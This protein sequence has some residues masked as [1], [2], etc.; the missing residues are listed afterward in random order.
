MN[1]AAQADARADASQQ[2]LFSAQ[3]GNMKEKMPA[4]RNIDTSTHTGK[5]VP[6]G[7]EALDAGRKL[8][9]TNPRHR[10]V[11]QRVLVACIN[12]LVTLDEIE[13]RIE[14]DPDATDKHMAPFFYAQWLVDA[15][16]LICYDLDVQG[17]LI[18]RE[19]YPDL[20]DDEY[21]DLLEG[22][23]YSATPEGITVATE[24]D[25][26]ARI[27]VFAERNTAYTACYRD[28]LEYLT[29]PHHLG[30]VTHYL[31]AEVLPRLDPQDAHVKNPTK[32]VDELSD[33]GAIAFR[34]GWQTTEEGVRA[35]QA[36]SKE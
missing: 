12:N 16:L 35:I 25:P 29:T 31:K 20:E 17:N 2:E 9:K 26:A 28:I 21:D 6:T 23:A 30:E 15:G 24:F 34:G 11:L 3:R 27:L 22:Y 19:D 36:L 18:T 10:I 7:D 5:A 1:N 8:L 4:V 33:I 14:E 13:E 32:F